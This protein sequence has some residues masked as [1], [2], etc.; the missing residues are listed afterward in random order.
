MPSQYYR[1][2]SLIPLPS[3]KKNFL[4]L[5]MALYRGDISNFNGYYTDLEKCKSEIKILKN[6]INKLNHKMNYKPYISEN[7]RYLDFDP[8]NKTVKKLNNVDYLSYDFDARFLINKYRAFIIKSASSTLSWLLLTEKP[9]IYLQDNF[10]SPIRKNLIEDFN[11]HFSFDVQKN[12]FSKDIKCLFN[13]PFKK[14]IE[15]IY[16]EKKK[17]ERKN[18]IKN[19]L[20]SMMEVQEKEPLNL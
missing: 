1:T 5:G 2:N 12:N 15:H 19:I 10:V 9:I 13:K 3:L 4:Y 11:D 14:E 8:I 18:L 17:Y 20:A 6:I 16:S 7:P